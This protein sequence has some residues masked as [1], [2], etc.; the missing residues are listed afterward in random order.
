MAERRR[1]SLAE[2]V[3][4]RELKPDA[5]DVEPERRVKLSVSVPLALDLRLTMA[6]KRAGVSKR[7]LVESLLDKH[8]PTEG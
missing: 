5:P 7:A 6:A 1:P 2:V 8:L 3:A 4:Q